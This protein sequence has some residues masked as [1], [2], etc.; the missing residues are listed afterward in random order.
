MEMKN[1]GSFWKIYM[2]T[3]GKKLIEFRERN[4]LEILNG[5]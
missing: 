1:Y 5:K 4:V 2:Q 3:D